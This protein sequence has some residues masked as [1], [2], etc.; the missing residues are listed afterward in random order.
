MVGECVIG[1]LKIKPE[2][3]MISAEDFNKSLP[4]IICNNKIFVYSFSLLNKNCR[5]TVF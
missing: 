4:T 5:T 3:Q 2:L 1:F